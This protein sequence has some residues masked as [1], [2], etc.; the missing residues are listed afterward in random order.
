MSRSVTSDIFRGH[1][2]INA[3][4]LRHVCV[5]TFSFNCFTDYTIK[6]SNTKITETD[7]TLKKYHA[8]IYFL[9]IFF[10]HWYIWIRAFHMIFVLGHFKKEAGSTAVYVFQVS[11]YQLIVSCYFCNSPML[12]TGI[13]LKEGRWNENG[14]KLIKIENVKKSEKS[15]RLKISGIS[16]LNP[17]HIKAQGLEKN[18][19]LR[20]C[21]FFNFCIFSVLCTG[22]LLVDCWLGNRFC[23]QL[24]IF[25]HIGL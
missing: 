10:C 19:E 21:V 3:Q 23:K 8:S 14:G 20:Y 25:S 18:I 22:I 5:S 1:Q 24:N 12:Y 11:S 9:T 17:W 6:L 7:L 16:F 4:L 15:E 2:T 13:L